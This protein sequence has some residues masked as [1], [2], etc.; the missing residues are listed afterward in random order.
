MEIIPVPVPLGGVAV[1]A[2]AGGFGFC[3]GRKFELLGVRMV[4]PSVITQHAANFATMRVLGSD[5]STVIW[6]YSTATAAE[7]T[8]TQSEIYYTSNET[9][10]GLPGNTVQDF[11][12]AMT[13]A[14]RTYDPNQPLEVQVNKAGS[15][16]AV[17]DAGIT[18]LIRYL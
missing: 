3:P 4:T 10:P 11:E 12:A 8:T 1:A 7:G 13:A 15:G 14:L 6:E 17:I 5:E 18:L 16:V 2:T 9:A